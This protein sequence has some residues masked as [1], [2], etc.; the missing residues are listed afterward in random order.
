MDE[1]WTERADAYRANRAL[2]DAVRSSSCSLTLSRSPLLT[3]RTCRSRAGRRSAGRR[4]GT[5]ASTST[6]TRSGASLAPLGPLLA[7]SPRSPRPP[8]QLQLD[9]PL[10]QR[11]QHGRRPAH[12]CDHGASSS[13]SF[14][15]RL[16]PRASRPPARRALDALDL[17]HELFICEST[18]SPVPSEYMLTHGLF[19]RAQ[20]LV[21]Q[22]P[23]VSSPL[24]GR[25]GV[26]RVLT[27]LLA[28]SRHHRA[29]QGRRE[30][31]QRDGGQQH[32]QDERALALPRRL[33][34]VYEGRAGR[35]VTSACTLLA[36]CCAR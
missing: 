13:S 4:R 17:V 16:P 27:C 25:K 10:G 33:L 7:C 22:G 34:S 11:R 30:L 15:A 2:A 8:L 5:R 35:V 24:G 6:S 28:R 21:P 1:V 12:R 19:R 32:E 36:R 31:V 26:A 18:T 29:Q 9:G 23:S 14:F 3:L 20:G